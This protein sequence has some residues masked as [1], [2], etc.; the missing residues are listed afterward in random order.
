MNTLSS[1][2]P[3]YSA[4][5]RRALVYFMA[6]ISAIFSIYLV[7]AYS[8]H[9]VDQRNLINNEFQNLKNT[10]KILVEHL[11]NHAT[12]LKTL[13]STKEFQALVISNDESLLSVVNKQFENLILKSDEYTSIQYLDNFGNEKIRTTGSSPYPN[14]SI[15]LQS[16]SDDIKTLITQNPDQIEYLLSPVFYSFKEKL[17]QSQTIVQLLVPVTVE[18]SYYGILALDILANDMM[19]QYQ[20]IF[21]KAIGT[22]ILANQRGHVIYL[23]HSAGE[24]FSSSKIL[25]L[26][27]IE[28]GILNKMSSAQNGELET[29]SGR[30]L[31]HRIDVAQGEF[32]RTIPS[33]SNNSRETNSPNQASQTALLSGSSWYNLVFI[34][35]KQLQFTPLADLTS[36]PIGVLSSLAFC[37]VCAIVLASSRTRLQHNMLELNEQH[38]LVDTGQ[39]VSQ[40]GTWV[41]HSSS[42]KMIWSDEMFRI[43]AL[44]PQNFSPAFDDYLN[45]VHPE[46]R[47]RF[48]NEFKEICYS[49]PQSLFHRIYDRQGNIRDVCLRT[50]GQT[51][52]ETAQLDLV[53]TIQDISELKDEFLSEYQKHST[54]QR[55]VEK[56]QDA[57][58]QLKAIRDPHGA[59]VDFLYLDVNSAFEK[60][61]E[62]E[63]E[64][65]L[66][67]T[68]LEISPKTGLTTIE[69]F[70]NAINDSKKQ[71]ITEQQTL[72]STLFEVTVFPTD[73]DQIAV[74]FKDATQARANEKQRLEME[75]LFESTTEAIITCDSDKIITQ[76]NKA[77]E[78][79]SGYSV[80]EVCGQHISSLRSLQHD[81]EFYLNIDSALVQNG[82]WHGDMWTRHKNG[83]LISTKTA[84]HAIKDSNQNT[85]S[86]VYLISDS[87]LANQ[88]EE[89]IAYI[90]QHDMLTGLAN[91]LAFSVHIA[92]ALETSNRHKDKMALLYLDLDGFKKINETFGHIGGDQCL[93]IIGNR[94]KSCVR[95]N[96]CVARLGG[97]EFAIIVEDLH[98]PQDLN[99]L[100]KKITKSLSEPIVY[101]GENIQI[102]TSIG[103]SIYPDDSS[104]VDELLQNADTAMY[105]VKARNPGTYEFYSGVV[106]IAAYQNKKM[107]NDLHRALNNDE[108]K[109]FYQPQI[110][111]NSGKIRG[112]EA[113]LRWQHPTKGLILPDEILSYAKSAELIKPLGD[114]V[115]N[116]VCRQVALWKRAKLPQIHISVNLSLHQFLRNHIVETLQSALSSHNISMDD[117]TLELEITEEILH[118]NYGVHKTLSELQTMGVRIALE[119]FGNI[120][121]SLRELKELPINTLKVDAKF[122]E[123][124]SDKSDSTRNSIT[125]AIVSTGH[126]LG[127]RVIATCVETE[128]QMQQLSLMGCDDVQGY[129]FSKAVSNDDIH[130]LLQKA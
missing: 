45:F 2:W 29:H 12:I 83:E 116:E 57:Y 107:E 113:L 89:H 77:F 4:Y 60:L 27:Q 100:A 78:I 84:I 87:N 110:Q 92:Q 36:H 86:Y 23:P 62:Q 97:D 112:M 128:A 49:T 15:Q 96:D 32:L 58:I 69:S 105:K 130:D 95:A 34:S 123:S 39:Q 99:N 21:S 88:A 71:K 3:Y 44:P 91:R 31:Y 9:Q 11:S 46:D 5:F 114:W 126:A 80:Q 13:S 22:P 55:I 14:S 65:I 98:D 124:L 122:L 54:R 6:L 76:A 59:I 19:A 74:F 26:S 79:M 127:M 73:K 33:Q 17:R 1:P 56:I 75:K 104:T 41:W 43:L 28:P 108:L 37:L 115:I 67:R 53:G 61:V 118:A 52:F 70:S 101:T 72:A 85:I 10:E 47:E 125:S 20:Q 82:N 35:Q 93:R 68:I 30:Y 66:H 50:S 8:Q 38:N 16:I 102:S 129:L 40:L 103:I 24:S 120:M 7:F 42:G 109:L 81:D 18:R 64:Q 119:N 94:I 111:V 121:T 117:F 48:S 63:R 106:G 90:A 25:N 51:Y